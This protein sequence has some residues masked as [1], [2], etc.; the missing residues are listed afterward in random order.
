VR[1]SNLEIIHLNVLIQFFLLVENYQ[2]QILQLV[3]QQSGSSYNLGGLFTGAD[4]T[5]NTTNYGVFAE[6]RSTKNII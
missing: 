3:V 5:P 6:A 1:S 2:D 4:N